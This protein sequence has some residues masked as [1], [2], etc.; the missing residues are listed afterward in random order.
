MS[1]PQ[2]DVKKQTLYASL[3]AIQKGAH[4]QVSLNMCKL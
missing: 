3:Y 1:N 2:S 4:F